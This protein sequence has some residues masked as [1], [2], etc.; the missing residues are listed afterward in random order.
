[1][2][3]NAKWI[4]KVVQVE[5]PIGSSDFRFLEKF[6]KQKGYTFN[7]VKGRF[8]C[9]YED[10]GS[11]ERYNL[12]WR[13]KSTPKTIINIFEGRT[14]PFE[15]T[16]RSI[17]YPVVPQCSFTIKG[18]GEDSDEVIKALF[19]NHFEIVNLSKGGLF[20]KFIKRDN[21]AY[22]LYKMNN[23]FKLYFNGRDTTSRSLLQ[24]FRIS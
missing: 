7:R 4:N 5:L 15:D 1:M 21:E 23:C 11:S 20:Q 3:I 14:L 10:E 13:M 17:V 24:A 2:S 19:H 22:L 8:E 6:L 18:V 12:L 16:V 9:I